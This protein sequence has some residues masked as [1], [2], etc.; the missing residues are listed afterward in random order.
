MEFPVKYV[1]V[2]DKIIEQREYKVI[3]DIDVAALYRV[4]P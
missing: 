2:E 1:E 3:L 4:F